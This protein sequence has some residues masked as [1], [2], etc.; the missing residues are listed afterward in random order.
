MRGAKL[1]FHQENWDDPGFSRQK[2][3]IEFD[4]FEIET[5]LIIY[6][7]KMHFQIDL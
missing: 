6:V 1:I 5:W 4:C 7:D 3:I 2:K